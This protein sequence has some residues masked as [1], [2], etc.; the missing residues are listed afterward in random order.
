MPASPRRRAAALGFCAALLVAVGLS[1]ASL[2]LPIGSGLAAEYFTSP[3]WTGTPVRSTVDAVPSTSVMARNW[4]NREP[5]AFSVRWT[6]FLIVD[7]PGAYTFAT[8][9][10]DGSVLRVDNQVVVDNAGRHSPVSVSGT[11]DLDSGPHLIVLEYFQ[12]GGP[13]ELAWTWSR[14][15]EA[16]APVPSWRLSPARRSLAAAVASRIAR[17]ARVIAILAAL[18]LGAFL[19]FGRPRAARLDA[20][21]APRARQGP[22]VY[23]ATL[24]LFVALAVVHTWPLA[25]NP[26]RLSRNDNGDTLLNEWTV[27][28]LAHQAVHDPVHLFDGNMFYPST[29]TVTYSEALVTQAAM[30]A[31]LLWAGASPVLV[32][33]LLVIAGF[34]L[35]GWTMCLV[36]ARWTGD[37]TAGLVAGLVMGFNAHTL[38]RI[39]HLQ[40]QHVE[41]L[42][43]TLL[44][45]DRLLA[46][47][48]ARHALALAGWFSLQAL[49]SFHLLVFTAVACVAGALVRPADWWDRRRGPRIAL[50]AGAA[51]LVSVVI[52][53]PM[54]LAYW[55]DYTAH[56]MERTF[57][58]AAGFAATWRDYLTTPSRFWTWWR[59]YW[60]GLTGLFPGGMGLALA[61]VALARGTAFRDPR[62]RMCLALGV[63]GVVLSLGPATPIYGW[64]Y[65]VLPPLHAIRAIS[66]FGYLGIVAVAGLAGFGWTALRP[67]LRVGW[68]PA[69]AAV[70]VAVAAIEPLAAPLGLSRFEGIPPVYARLRDVPGAVVAELPLAEPRYQFLNAPYLLNSTA[71][72]KP[73]LNGYSGF[74]PE[75]YL[76]QY[77]ALR[78]FPA[79]SAIDALRQFGV[80]HIFVHLGSYGEEDRAVIRESPGLTLTA[81]E[82]DIALYAVAGALPGGGAAADRLLDDDRP[83]EVVRVDDEIEHVRVVADERRARPGA[84]RGHGVGHRAAADGAVDREVERPASGRRGILRLPAQ[85]QRAHFA[86]EG[87]GLHVAV[88]RPGAEL[89]PDD[90]LVDGG[91]RGRLRSAGAGEHGR[92]EQQ[93]QAH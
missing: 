5:G 74:V 65:A 87:L 71:H 27:A 42:P 68:R 54:L 46:A 56:G 85:P 2:V 51:A 49:A 8:T 16:S 93:A 72:W 1:G 50:L 59:P 81:S 13:Y 30:G 35:T 61:A 26:A 44:A 7:R 73:M 17:A 33:N 43:L 39:P 57:E 67:M 20:A 88:P 45:L 55:S 22:W 79:P 12:G 34:A 52:L 6:G 91:G 82:G 40:A 32:Y 18:L 63:A 77:D 29:N 62:A 78:A 21:D 48:R 86:E 9:S 36:V 80:T 10:D 14:G 3:D 41:F 25:S 90:R 31:P 24:A 4:L 60:P 53:S 69:A 23:G 84:G 37:W 83:L 11:I 47:P 19:A 28:W 76:R 89:V 92:E 70:V 66:R 64:L 38:M 58:T 15:G 75:S